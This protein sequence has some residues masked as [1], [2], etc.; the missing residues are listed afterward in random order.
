MFLVSW[1]FAFGIRSA[2]N[3][4]EKMGGE[5]N[6]C[7][8]LHNNAPL[9]RSVFVKDFLVNN[10]MTTLEHLPFPILASPQLFLPVPST[11]IRTEE[12]ALL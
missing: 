12:T 5:K 9:N 1:F 6:I 10:N 2:E 8:I 3:G 11:G 4:P 7:D